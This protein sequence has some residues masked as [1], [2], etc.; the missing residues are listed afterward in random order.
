[1]YVQGNAISRAKV[2]CDCINDGFVLVDAQLGY[3][4][5]KSVAGSKCVQSKCMSCDCG[6]KVVCL[7]ERDG[8]WRSASAA[9][10][11]QGFQATTKFQDRLSSMRKGF[12]WIQTR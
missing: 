8:L 9:G 7:L 4:V 1:M 11:Y 10:M 3:K 12:K 2:E 6:K 5:E